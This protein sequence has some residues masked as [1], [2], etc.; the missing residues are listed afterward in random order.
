MSSTRFRQ[1]DVEYANSFHNV[2]GVPTDE[3]AQMAAAENLSE[4]VQRAMRNGRHVT[5]QGWDVSGT[6]PFGGTCWLRC[7]KGTAKTLQWVQ[8]KGPALVDPEVVNVE[9]YRVEAGR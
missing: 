6:V 5:Y 7:R 9:Y 3:Q 1:E 8:V 4:E 2:G